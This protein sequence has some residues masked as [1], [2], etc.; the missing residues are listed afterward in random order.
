MRPTAA[1]G[2]IGGSEGSTS[3]KVSLPVAQPTSARLAMMTTLRL[4]IPG[5]RVAAALRVELFISHHIKSCR[6]DH[7][8]LKKGPGL[9]FQPSYLDPADSLREARLPP[10]NQPSR[11]PHSVVSPAPCGSKFS[12]I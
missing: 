6:A 1:L 2:R 12:K 4:T 11:E 9:S 8:A 7:A 10:T 3:L 5:T